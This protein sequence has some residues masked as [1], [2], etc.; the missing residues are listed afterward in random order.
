MSVWVLVAIVWGLA[1]G[2]VLFELWAS[3]DDRRRRG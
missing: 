3:W 1:V 2:L